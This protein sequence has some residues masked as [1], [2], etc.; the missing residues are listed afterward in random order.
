MW[1]GLLFSVMAISLSVEIATEDAPSSLAGH[2]ICD[3]EMLIK[4]FRERTVQCLILADYTQPSPYAIETLLLHLLLDCFS[5]STSPTGSWM[6]IGLI[7]RAAMRLGLHRDASHY[8]NISVFKGEMQRRHWALI[9][10][11]DLHISCQI[12]LPRNIR[13]GM[14]DTKPPR[15]LYD[16]DM[17]RSCTSL[18]P[19]RSYFES[20]PIRYPLMKSAISRVYGI[21]VDR[22]NSILPISYN[23]IMTLDSMLNKV[24]LEIPASFRVSSLE[25]LRNG[26]HDI[27]VQKFSLDL[28]Y[29]RARCVLHRRYIS[30]PTPAGVSPY[31][32]SVRVCIDAAV[33]LL[34]SQAAIYRDAKPGG[35][36]HNQRWKLFSLMTHDFFQAAMLICLYLSHTPTLVED[37]SGLVTTSVTWSKDELLTTLEMSQKISEEAGTKSKDSARV[38]KAM[39]LLL[40]RL[41]KGQGPSSISG[42]QF[43]SSIASPY[44]INRGSP[45]RKI[46]QNFICRTFA[47][48][49]TVRFDGMDSSEFN[50]AGSAVNTPGLDWPVV[51]QNSHLTQIPQ[52]T[53]G[54]HTEAYTDRDW[55][56][57]SAAISFNSVKTNEIELTRNYG[58]SSF[59]AAF[60]T[61]LLISGS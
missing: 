26:T 59:K 42:I 21:I 23:D 3:P 49:F 15:N 10:H 55:V 53:R 41:K 29:Q 2:I 18:P 1:I 46:F 11:M 54:P 24:Y 30:L 40:F 39:K 58:T 14:F 4:L 9:E 48:H 45:S 44:S 31:R 52:S 47:K 5:C 60:W 20:T 7:T 19:S 37:A 17:D 22:T 13:E 43:P 6:L 51:S 12:G 61:R 36:L 33:Q 32:Y 57:A 35:E 34:Q 27:R 50:V 56:S 25:D 16:Q 28:C 8:P 38:A